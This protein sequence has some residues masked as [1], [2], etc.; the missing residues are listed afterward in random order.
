MH[1]LKNS[2]SFRIG[3]LTINRTA[4]I[5]TAKEP[6]LL[7]LRKLP[8]WA[9]DERPNEIT[10]ADVNDDSAA[11]LIPEFDTPEET[12]D[13]INHMKADFFEALLS[14]WTTDKMLWPKGRSLQLFDEWFTVQFH[15]V[16]YDLDLAVQLQ[17]DED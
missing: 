13:Y 5:I 6:M 3:M 12:W 15:T 14:G 17:H 9:P 10:L 8:D 4:L 7:W 16:V 2:G 1:F 11:Y